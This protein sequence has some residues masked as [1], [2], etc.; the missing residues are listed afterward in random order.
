MNKYTVP[1]IPDILFREQIERVLNRKLGYAK[2]ARPFKA[3]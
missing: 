2:Q 3:R 1:R